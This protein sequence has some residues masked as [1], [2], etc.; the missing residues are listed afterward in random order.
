MRSLLL[1]LAVVALLA[2]VGP[3]RAEFDSGG[4]A[5]AK[6]K[7]TGAAFDGA[8]AATRT[9]R[10]IDLMM[11][12][13]ADIRIAVAAARVWLIRAPAKAT[14]P[15]PIIKNP[16]NIPRPRR[17]ADQPLSVDWR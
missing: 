14:M 6:A 4:I 15:Q 1:P 9:A 5:S 16:S 12:D 8:I 3:T 2:L 11:D 10:R 17:P 7:A 13:V